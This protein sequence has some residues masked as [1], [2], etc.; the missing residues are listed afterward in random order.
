M[1]HGLSLVSAGLPQAMARP[2]LMHAV[3]EAFYDLYERGNVVP[4]QV[5]IWVKGMQKASLVTRLV[6]I[7]GLPCPFLVHNLGRGLPHCPAAGTSRSWPTP[8]PEK[9]PTLRHL[10]ANGGPR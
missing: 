8:H 4:V 10:A 3:L 9:G 2:V 1:H 5:I 7:P 6:N